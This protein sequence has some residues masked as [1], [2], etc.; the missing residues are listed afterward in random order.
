MLARRSR[1]AP[2]RRSAW[3]SS[4]AL[5]L[6]FAAAACAGGAV[7]L[8]YRVPA[9]PSVTYAYADTT[10]VAVS[11]MGQALE[12]AMRGSADYGIDFARA[13]PGVE[14]TMTVERLDV[15]VTVPMAGEET[16]DESGVDGP[17]VFTLDPTGD[18]AIVAS[19]DIS[20]TAAR[21]ISALS[22]A[23][24]FFP[25]LPA[26]AVGPG[27]RWVDTVSYEGDAELGATAE[28]SIV[29]YTV[30]GDTVVGGRSLLRIGLT[31]TSRSSNETT[32]GGFQV[33]QSSELTLDGHVLWDEEAGIMFELVRNGTG[34]GTVRIPMA[35]QP[36]PI[37][38]TTTQRARLSPPA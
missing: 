31:G 25:G 15:S 37:E 11:F 29:T 6:S 24:S 30:V 16:V 27:D 5:A 33:A 28:E 22:T 34:T 9:T 10:L 19:P 1:A 18:A 12:I 17:L 23:H 14:V 7:E 21:M 32:M 20:V 26:R 8:G 2:V 4:A 13:A 35:Q 3:R 36:L 38:L